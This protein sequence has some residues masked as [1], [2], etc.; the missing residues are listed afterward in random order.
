M[1]KYTKIFAVI[2][3]LIIIMSSALIYEGYRRK[4]QQEGMGMVAGVTAFVTVMAAAVAMSSSTD[5]IINANFAMLANNLWEVEDSVLVKSLT[6]K[7]EMA[8][9][10]KTVTDAQIYNMIANGE[11]CEIEEALVSD[12]WLSR[13]EADE[14]LCT[15]INPDNAYNVLDMDLPICMV[16]DE[17]DNRVE[18]SYYITKEGIVFIWPPFEY[19]KE[20]YVNSQ[21]L[22]TD[23]YGNSITTKNSSEMFDDDFVVTVGEV[24]IPVG[25][26][27]K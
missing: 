14:T 27:L 26:Y 25:E 5:T 10:A 16:Y 8:M 12:L 9:N 21:T 1:K 2:I 11:D 4:K 24:E 20:Y 6:L 23:E 3:A 18:A 15:R 22:V 19:E 13:M 7:G 17:Y